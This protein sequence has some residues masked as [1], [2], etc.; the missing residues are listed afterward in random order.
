[1]HSQSGVRA[2]RV[3]GGRPVGGPA[4]GHQGKSVFVSIRNSAR[5]VHGGT[6]VPT[7]LVSNYNQSVT[8]GH[9]GPAVSVHFHRCG[10]NVLGIT[11]PSPSVS[12]YR[13]S[14][15]QGHMGPGTLPARVLLN[16]DRRGPCGYWSGPQWTRLDSSRGSHRKGG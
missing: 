8:T 9:I 11:V 13:W 16:P 4:G 3:T 15:T 12:S 2:G 1:M 5:T 14:V 6:A 10:R 7:D